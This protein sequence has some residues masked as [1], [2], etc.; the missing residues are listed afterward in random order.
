MSNGNPYSESW[1]K[2][3]KFCPVFPNRLSG[4]LTDA[5]VFIASFVEGCDH[6]H[7]HTSLGLNKPADT[8]YSLAAGKA[9][10]RTRR[11]SPKRDCRPRNAWPRPRPRILTLP[12]PV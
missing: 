12:D 3:L 9:G 2:T 8:H 10:D 1:F 4:S 11:S 6:S 5:R 7:R